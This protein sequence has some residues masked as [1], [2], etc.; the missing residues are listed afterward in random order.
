M[1][2]LLNNEEKKKMVQPIREAPSLKLTL[3][4]INQRIHLTIHKLLGRS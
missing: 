3:K 2:N 1:L 4:K